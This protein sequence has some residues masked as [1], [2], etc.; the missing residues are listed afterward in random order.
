MQR[1]LAQFPCPDAPGL[2]AFWRAEFI[3]HEVPPVEPE[4]GV[5]TADAGFAR[6]TVR[7][8]EGLGE[9]EVACDDPGLMVDLRTGIGDHMAEFAPDLPPLVWT[10]AGEAGAQPPNFSTARVA[11]CT[12]LGAS[13]LRMTL[14]LEPAA[15]QRFAGAHWHFRL[16]RPAVAGRAPVWPVLN[17]RGTLTWPKGEDTLLDRV[18]TVRDLD[19]AAGTISFDIFR[20]D[21]GLTCA[22]ADGQPVGETVGLMGPGGKAGP[23]LPE[24]GW[25]LCGGDETALPALLRGIAGLP[26]GT[27]GRAV[28]LV[29]AP[30]DRQPLAGGGLDITWLYRSAGATEADLVAEIAATPLPDNDAWLWFAASQQAAREVRQHGREVLALPRERLTSIAYWQ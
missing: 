26:Q 9:I 14:A 22:W 29:G 2:V 25:L 30:E 27:R 10:G 5:I 16:L 15:L 18:Y 24:A 19:A 20:H 23:E 3:E 4:P 1:S 6:V 28:L 13:W 8:L 21:G 12:P 17:A 11:G 7:A